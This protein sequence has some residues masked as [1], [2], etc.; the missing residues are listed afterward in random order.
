MPGKI[1]RR[2][3]VRRQPVGRRQGPDRPDDGTAEY[4]DL[5]MAVEVT[6]VWPG[7]SHHDDLNSVL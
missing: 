6:V 4:T 2:H 3:Q 1:I 5:H 7:S